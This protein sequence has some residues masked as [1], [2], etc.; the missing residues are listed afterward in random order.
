MALHRQD[1]NESSLGSTG[2]AGR[3][4]PGEVARGVARGVGPWGSWPGG[5]AQG[6]GGP[7]WLARGGPQG[8]TPPGAQCRGGGA[9]GAPGGRAPLAGPRE[10]TRGAPGPL[11]TCGPGG[12]GLQSVPQLI[13]ST[14]HKQPSEKNVLG[15]ELPHGRC[16]QY[17]PPV[18]SAA[19]GSGPGSSH[20]RACAH[21]CLQAVL[22]GGLS[23]CPSMR[24]IGARAAASRAPAGGCQ[25]FHRIGAVRL[26]SLQDLAI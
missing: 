4:A 14:L 10:C 22:V 6:G 21:C 12:A 26:G 8:G 1:P 17:L 16:R 25:W 20:R 15:T 11:Q 9:R 5:V 3:R 24:A 18:G 7:G 19:E 23:V 2:A 13:C